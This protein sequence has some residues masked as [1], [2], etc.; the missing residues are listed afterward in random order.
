MLAGDRPKPVRSAAP[1][2]PFCSWKIATRLSGSAALGGELADHV[3]VPSVEPSSTMM[4]SLRSA[5][6][7]RAS[8]IWRTVAAR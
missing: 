1:L 4:I 6:R 5:A 8:R 2:P 7:A 3:G